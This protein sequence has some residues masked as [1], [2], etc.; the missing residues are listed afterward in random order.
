MAAKKLYFPVSLVVEGAMRLY[1]KQKLFLGF[2]GKLL[3][4]ADSDGLSLFHYIFLL[5][6]WE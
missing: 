2:L 4:E 3:K 1:S 5:L 6:S